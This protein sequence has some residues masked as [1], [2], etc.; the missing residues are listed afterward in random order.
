LLCPLDLI[1]TVSLLLEQ[2]WI[3]S[4]PSL[5]RRGGAERRGGQSGDTNTATIIIV[6][7]DG[8][9]LLAECLPSVIEAVNHAGGK[10]EILVVDNGSTDGSIQF[11]QEHFPHVRV[12]PLA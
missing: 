12:L 9:H 7:W 4:F 8:K 2:L 10:H 6:T 5:K 1:V 3:L 11:L